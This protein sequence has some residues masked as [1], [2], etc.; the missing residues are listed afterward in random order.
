[1]LA[2]IRKWTTFLSALL[3]KIDKNLS[4][5]TKMD[6]ILRKCNFLIG[7][8]RP[9]WNKIL[10]SISFKYKILVIFHLKLVK[11]KKLLGFILFTINKFLKFM[12]KWAVTNKEQFWSIVVLSV[13][14]YSSWAG[15][16]N[17]RVSPPYG[18]TTIKWSFCN[19]QDRQKKSNIRPKRY[20]ETKMYSPPY[21]R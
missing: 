8:H 18:S 4:G 7:K 13:R 10:Y 19:K 5:S 17:S 12:A 1:M 9:Q 21:C 6:C 14:N 16:Q 11:K 20:F 15:W 2:F 3:P